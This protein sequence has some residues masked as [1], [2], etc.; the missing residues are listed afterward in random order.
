M[1]K[2]TVFTAGKIK[3]N[4]QTGGPAGGV[5]TLSKGA[6]YSLTTK[7]TYNLVI[8]AE[9]TAAAQTYTLGL[10][11]GQIAVVKNFN[12]TNAFTLKNVAGDTGTSIAVGKSVLIIASSTANG[13]TVISLD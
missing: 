13:S 12:A 2:P 7:E 8:K 10:V 9:M 1:T 6:S 11:D 4:M 5:L 3:E